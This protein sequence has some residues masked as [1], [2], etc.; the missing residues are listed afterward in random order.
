MKLTHFVSLSLFTALVWLQVY[1]SARHIYSGVA[2]YKIELHHARE[3]L[4]ARETELKISQEHFLEFRQNVATLM[5]D[6]IREKGQGEEGYPFRSLAS[7]ITKGESVQIKTT[8]AKTLFDEGKEFYRLGQY[9]KA[10]RVFKSLIDNFGFSPHVVD[11]YFLMA[12]GY[13]QNGEFEECT[14]VIQRMIEL[15]PSHELTGFAM[16][17]LGGIYKTNNRTEEAIDI[18][19][20]VLRSFPQRGVAAQAKASLRGLDL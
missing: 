16:I 12:D 6:V 13:F 20:A 19:R 10:N 1:S 17:R 7:V 11:A 9:H 5:P 3:L 18:Y 8:L 4:E 15:F 2:E 14:T